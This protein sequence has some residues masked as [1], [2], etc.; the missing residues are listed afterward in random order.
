MVEEEQENSTYSIVDFRNVKYSCRSYV[1]VNRDLKE[2]E[3]QNYRFVFIDEVR[4]RMMENIVFLE[5]K[6]AKKNCEVF[7]LVNLI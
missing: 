2:L 5:T 4:G 6:M 3:R 1:D 7:Q